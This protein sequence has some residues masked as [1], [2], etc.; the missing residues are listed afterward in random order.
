MGGFRVNC[1]TRSLWENTQ[2]RLPNCWLKDRY[3]VEVCA[4]DDRNVICF[5]IAEMCLSHLCSPEQKHNARK[6][7]SAEMKN[8]KRRKYRR[9]FPALANLT[10][11]SH[12]TT[13]QHA[14]QLNHISWTICSYG[15][16][17]ILWLWDLNEKSRKWHENGKDQRKSVHK[18][19]R[20]NANVINAPSI[21]SAR[22]N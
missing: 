5:E 3:N 10:V 14:S 8:T 16:T 20:Q 1:S 12:C 6:Q 18:H 7:T 15:K 2:N 4:E 13:H 22:R 21:F 17:A 19:E 11:G 9:G